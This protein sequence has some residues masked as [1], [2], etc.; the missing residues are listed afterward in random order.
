MKLSRLALATLAFALSLAGSLVERDADAAPP[1]TP[2]AAPTDAARLDAAEIVTL[3]ANAGIRGGKALVVD[4]GDGALVAALHARGY[5]VDLVERRPDRARILLAAAGW[6]ARVV[7]VRMGEIARPGTIA[8]PGRPGETYDVVVVDGSSERG[9]LAS[10]ALSLPRLP[11]EGTPT[12]VFFRDVDLAPRPKY[13]GVRLFRPSKA[14]GATYDRVAISGIRPTSALPLGTRYWPDAREVDAVH[15]CDALGECEVT[16]AGFLTP[17]QDGT[18]DLRGVDATWHVSADPG[19]RAELL[20]APVPPASL[21]AQ[22]VAPTVPGARLAAVR[23]TARWSASTHRFELT[24]ARRVSGA[25][26]PDG[27]LTSASSS[28]PMRQLTH[29]LHDAFHAA[30]SR[31]DAAAERGIAQAQAAW[32]DVVGPL[33]P[34]FHF[35]V[36]LQEMRGHYFPARAAGNPELAARALVRAYASS[37]DAPWQ[38][39]ATAKEAARVLARV[40]LER[41]ARPDTR[42][43]ALGALAGL[44]SITCTEAQERAYE[45]TLESVNLDVTVWAAGLPLFG[46]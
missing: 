1:A 27:V 35:T 43:R 30:A 33:A 10:R 14:A 12:F 13:A 45:S 20:A 25:E 41:A 37:R 4:D 44:C 3:V 15:G 9:A 38:L 11:T 31:N 29:S 39:A 8:R 42:A 26:V 40:E 34:L 22:L 28:P 17:L 32:R 36:P 2:V 7:T 24:G 19:A 21:A 18:F 6:P 5:E 46:E 23:G 16:V